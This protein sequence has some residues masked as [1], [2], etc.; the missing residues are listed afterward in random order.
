MN[1]TRGAQTLSTFPTAENRRSAGGH[2]RGG[3]LSEP[4][5]GSIV[6]LAQS[7]SS[8]FPLTPILRPRQLPGALWSLRRADRPSL[9]AAW[10]ALRAARST[11]RQ[12]RATNLAELRVPEPPP[13]PP[14]AARGVQAILRRRG[15]RCLV[16]A[17]VWQEW[18]AAHGDHHD[19]VIGVNAPGQAFSAHAWLA[20]S[21]DGGDGFVELARYAARR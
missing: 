2:A 16:S 10:W 21:P 17:A 3:S 5:P 15:E 4:R 20:G 14:S 13:L 7:M 8:P 11:R 1:L 6:L 18:H 9:R 12:L 19:L